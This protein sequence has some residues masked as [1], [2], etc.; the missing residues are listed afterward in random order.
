MQAMAVSASIIGDDI[1][2]RTRACMAI[3]KVA[4]H[5]MASTTQP[6]QIQRAPLLWQ[7]KRDYRLPG[8]M[9]HLCRWIKGRGFTK[10]IRFRPEHEIAWKIAYMTLH[11][12]HG[13]LLL[14]SGHVPVNSRDRLH[15]SL[16]FPSA[17][18]F[19]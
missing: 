12:L 9:D 16:S 10:D 19:P 8:R 17:F 4:N 7:S 11:R 18:A 3:R 14:H 6:V 2:I 13:L 15:Q 1:V 5:A